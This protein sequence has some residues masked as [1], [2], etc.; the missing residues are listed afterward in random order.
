[1][2]FPFIWRKTAEADITAWKAEADRQRARA[3]QAIK[4][5]ET[6]DF[7]RQQVLAQNTS[8]DTEN[9]RLKTAKFDEARAKQAADRIAL[10]QRAAAEARAEARAEKRRG[11]HLQKR[12]DDAVGLPAGRVEDSSPWQPA[13]QPPKPDKEAAS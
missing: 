4:A 6:A 9:R 10:L 7:N 11:D 13:Y 1:M 12:L 8:L 3:E 2:R 5:K